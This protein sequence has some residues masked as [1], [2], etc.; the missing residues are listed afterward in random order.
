MVIDPLRQCP[1]DTASFGEVRNPRLA[2]A[3]QA[4]ELPEQRPSPLGPQSCN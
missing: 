1:A 2:D 3:L 4:A